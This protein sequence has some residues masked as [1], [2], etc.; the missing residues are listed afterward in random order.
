MILL[1]TQ[2]LFN[3][4]FYAV[5]PFLAVVLTDDFRLGGAA[6]GL[7]LGI[8]TFSQQ[9]MFL[10]GGL[11]ADSL[12]AKA[13]ILVGCAVRCTGFL[14]LSASLW[15]T[16]PILGW[17]VLG[18]VLTG[19]GGA[20]FSPALNTLIAAAEG[21]RAPGHRITLFAWL[22]VFGEIGA[23]IG[24]VL[25]G[26]LFGWGFAIVAGAGAL[27]FALIGVL[28]SLVLPSEP[29]RRGGT[30]R[31]PGG[32]GAALWDR[33]FIAF[34]AINAV[35]LLTYN[36][37][38]LAM[39]T[40]MRRVG[41]GAVELGML[42]TWVSI[43]TVTLQL[44]IARWSGRL[45]PSAALRLGYLSSA[46]G[47][48]VLAVAAPR[49]PD[50]GWALVPAVVAVTLFALG[51]LLVQPTA[52]AAVASFAGERPTGSYFGLLATAGG[53][54]VLLGNVGI[55][56]L[57]DLAGT[58]GPSAIVPWAV[59]AALLLTAAVAVRI[60]WIWGSAA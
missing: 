58:P 55:G 4:G 17:F 24:P 48:L 56:S 44:P 10:V 60:R 9:G 59:L 2:L 7:V 42:F 35:D 37:L 25:G 1:G 21:H 15:S 19:L 49:V 22:T 20:L 45:A 26:L 18:T 5:V 29:R 34:A 6:V 33:R 54:A 3:V 14:T 13:V 39:P 27:M 8:R 23:A 31:V 47:F 41:A 52:L 12:G 43:L 51:H 30:R 28:L 16:E 32:G 53:I 36:Q 40:E 46:G 57:L 38:Y 11:L 50:P